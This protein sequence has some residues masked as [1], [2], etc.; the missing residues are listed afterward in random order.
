MSERV[1]G[2]VRWARAIASFFL[3]VIT[4]DDG[5][6]AQ[7]LG[8][9]ATIEASANVLFGAAR[10]RLIALTAGSQRA[11]STLE[12]QGG[13]LLSYA[14][15]PTEDEEREV[16]ARAVRIALGVDF[17]PF[18]RWSPFWFG[19]AESSL[20]QRIDRRYS[21]GAGAKLTFYREEDDDVSASLALLWEQTRAVDPEPPTPLTE[22]PARAAITMANCCSGRVRRSEPWCVA[23]P[24]HIVRHASVCTTH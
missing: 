8:W 4:A 5:A 17:R 18:D 3:A 19:T 21:T 10:G 22:T 12:V 23:V 9:S 14:D 13:F 2:G 11:D 15:S 7:E 20:Q 1:T 24:H 16:T 6:R